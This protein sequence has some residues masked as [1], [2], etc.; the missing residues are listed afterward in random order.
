[1]ERDALLTEDD[2][3]SLREDHHAL[4]KDDRFVQIVRDEENRPAQLTREVGEHSLLSRT[5]GAPSLAVGMAEIFSQALGGLVAA[6]ELG[7]GQ[8][9]R[10]E[11]VHPRPQR[12]FVE[13]QRA[14]DGGGVL[15]AVEVR[16]GVRAVDVR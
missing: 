5:G 2:R 16:A 12:R 13:L 14:A 7:Q 6:A 1:V 9:G 15:R 4:R 10:Q 8:V 3:R 11:R